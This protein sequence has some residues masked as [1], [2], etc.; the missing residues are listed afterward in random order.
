M[1]QGSS[2]GRGG[3]KLLVERLQVR[4][5]GAQQWVAQG[6]RLQHRL[7]VAFAGGV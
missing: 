3:T 6:L 1:G 5:E 2:A 4:L 7:P